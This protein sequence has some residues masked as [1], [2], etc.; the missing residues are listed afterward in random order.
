M[1]KEKENLEEKNE[2]TISKTE[3]TAQEE[4]KQVSLIEVPTEFGLAYST[5]EGNMNQ[6][7]YLVWLGNMFLDFKAAITGNQ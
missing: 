3:E 7:Q 1:V 6:D 2:E 4:V 5:P